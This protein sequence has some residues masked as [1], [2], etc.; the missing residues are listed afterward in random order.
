[1]PFSLQLLPSLLTQWSYGVTCWEV[2]SLGRS[3]YP[4]I[5]NHEILE[6]ISGGGRPKKPALCPEKLWVSLQ[7]LE[8]FAFPNY[9][10]VMAWNNTRNV[11]FCIQ[12]ICAV[13]NILYVLC[14]IFCYRYEIISCCWRYLPDN[15]PTFEEILLSLREYW[16]DA[17]LYAVQHQWMKLLYVIQCVLP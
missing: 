16:D 14:S 1:M 2:F 9:L 13:T 12:W 8:Q 3:P 6:H 5:E 4:G 7:C 17:H 15:R 10:C 11:K